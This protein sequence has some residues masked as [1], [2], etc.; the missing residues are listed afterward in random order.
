MRTMR[1]TSLLLAIGSIGCLR[2]P[3]W[4]EGCDCPE[5]Q[6]CRF[7][8]DPFCTDAPPECDAAFTGSCALEKLDD[9]C[10]EA[11]CPDIDVESTYSFDAQCW[12]DPQDERQF[13]MVNCEA[14]F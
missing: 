1:T 11:I 7:A 6:I 3:D 8:G 2:E 4:A 14:G 9:A 10:I 12:L 5:G 13:R